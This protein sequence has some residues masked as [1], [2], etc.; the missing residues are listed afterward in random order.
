MTFIRRVKE[1][2]LKKE[3]KRCAGLIIGGHN[4]SM[5]RLLGSRFLEKWEVDTVIKWLSE[6]KVVQVGEYSVTSTSG[7]EYVSKLYKY[8]A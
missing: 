3:I 7:I 2:F 1:W 5:V 4:D 8:I 6:R